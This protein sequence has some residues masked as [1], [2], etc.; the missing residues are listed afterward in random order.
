M[1]T[2]SLIFCSLL[3]MLCLFSCKKKAS[4]TKP[5]PQTPAVYV[6]EG[7]KNYFDYQ[8]GSYWIFYD[9][10][11]NNIDSMFVYRTDT[12]SLNWHDTAN[13]QIQMNLYLYGLAPHRDTLYFGI[14]LFGLHSQLTDQLG[15]YKYFTNNF[16]FDTG[17]DRILD[18]FFDGYHENTFIGNKLINGVA[19]DNVYQ[20][21]WRTA[22]S[23]WVLFNYCINA[24]NGFLTMLINTGDRNKKLYLLRSHIIR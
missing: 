5:Q 14:H 24:R 4:D 17:T 22:P 6:D 21:E 18:G 1:K 9:S 15:M 2:R 12:V 23:S 7:L 8:V 10:V 16:P 19:Y 20:I 13:E 11:N 3:L